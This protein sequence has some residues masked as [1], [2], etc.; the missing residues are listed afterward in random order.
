MAP[1]I[2]LMRFVISSENMFR[3]VTVCLQVPLFALYKSGVHPEFF[4]GGGADPEAIYN[5]CLILKI[6]L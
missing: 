3:L 6:M 2:S 5:L 1:N 4:I